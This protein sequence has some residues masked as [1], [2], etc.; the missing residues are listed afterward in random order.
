MTASPPGAASESASPPTEEPIE[1]SKEDRELL[2]ELELLLQWEL[3]TE[4][5][6]AEA[7]PIA[8]EEPSQ[9]AG[10]RTR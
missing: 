9:P 4:W 10:E 2:Q 6:P 3:L 7:L 1:L 5:D 8:I